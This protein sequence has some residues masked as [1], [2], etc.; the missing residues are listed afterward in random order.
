[1]ARG[2]A[3]PLQGNYTLELRSIRYLKESIMMN[4]LILMTSRQYRMSRNISKIRARKTG[5]KKLR[6][7]TLTYNLINLI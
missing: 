6:I 7:G 2:N 5:I 3:L 4:G 1:M